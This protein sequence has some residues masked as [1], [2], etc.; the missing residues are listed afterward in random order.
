MNSL[1]KSELGNWEKEEVNPLTL[2]IELRTR[3]SEL[4][5]LNSE[6]VFNSRANRMSNLYSLKTSGCRIARF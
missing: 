6:L 2:T 3:S 5:L 4:I 1:L